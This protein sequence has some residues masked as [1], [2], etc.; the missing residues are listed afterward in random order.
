MWEEKVIRNRKIFLE[1]L[2]YDTEWITPNTTPGKEFEDYIK[3]L[4]KR[5][6]TKVPRS[7]KELGYPES[8]GGYGVNV[9]SLQKIVNRE[10][11]RYGL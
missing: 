7:Y 9:T 10:R 6:P 4:V 11:K 8:I 2:G 5:K 3:K 1:K